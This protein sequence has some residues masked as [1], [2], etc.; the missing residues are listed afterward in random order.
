MPPRD[1]LDQILDAADRDLE[2][3]GPGFRLYLGR[4]VGASETLRRGASRPP[5]LRQRWIQQSGRSQAR[6][7]RRW[8]GRHG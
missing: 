7:L 8:R 1:E 2:A 5:G 4:A 6:R 3:M